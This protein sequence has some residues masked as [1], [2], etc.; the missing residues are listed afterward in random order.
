MGMRLSQKLL[1]WI[2][3]F[4]A[5]G[6]G[7]MTLYVILHSRTLITDMGMSDAKRTAGMAFE[8]LYASMSAGGGRE[9][10]RAVIERLSSIED[11]GEIRVIHGRPLD[12]QFGLMENRFP[13]DDLDMA[14]LAGRE[15]RHIE[16]GT[17]GE[18]TVRFVQPVFAG[19][20]CRR[21]HAVNEGEALG[22]ISISTSLSRYDGTLSRSVRRISIMGAGI[23]AGTAVM[24]VFFIVRVII[25]PVR[26][27]EKAARAIGEG[28]L[29]HRIEPSGSLEMSVLAD[30]FNRMTS[31]LRVISRELEKKVE[32]RTRELEKEM[33]VRK[34]SEEAVRHMAYH[35]PLTG[36]PNR[37]VLMDRVNQ[38]LA[39]GRWHGRIA[40][41]VYLDLDRFKVINDTLGHQ[42]GDTLLKAVADRLARCVRTGDTVVRQG[43]DEFIMLLQD[44]HRIDDITMVIKKVFSVFDSSFT[45][46]GRELAVTASIGISVYPDDGEDAE[47]LFK[48]AD[49]AMYK[50]KEEGRNK[51]KFFTPAMNSLF[52]KR[53]DIERRLLRAIEKEEFLLYYQPEVDISTG[54]V[55]GVEALLRWLDPEL[56]LLPP[57]DFIPVAEDTG[58]IIQIGEWALRAAC[59]QSKAWQDRGL[60]PVV[61][62]VNLSMRQFKQNDFLGSLV[63]ILEETGLDPAW[64]ELELTESIIMDDPESV[65]GTLKNLKAMG[66]RLTIDD[67]GTGYSSLEYLKRMPI[68]KLKIAQS[69]IKSITVDPDDV[70]I[71]STVI[72]IGHSMKMEVIAEGV[73]TVE[74]LLLLRTLRCDKVQ[75]FLVSRPAPAG[76]VERLLEKR[77]V[78]GPLWSGA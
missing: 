64:L 69:F 14:A 47:T 57:G 7:V 3:C 50:A 32:E 48:N 63:R 15:V 59:I 13:V 41:I 21:C 10:N 43:G 51:Y 77:G 61:V 23:L 27:F 34:R 16:R 8:A 45:V 40:A 2:I 19:E 9:E 70:A 36:L 76:E 75:G 55:A 11:M 28:G 30:E 37:L 66:V 62:A 29:A 42:A 52:L 18:G 46:A 68:N 56:G 74:Q 53:L 20:S 33:E 44:I 17:D 78:D 22:A 65:I 26:D 6:M 4:M 54:E 73:E 72:S 60:K 24:S 49:I 71:A 1:L 39:R 35:D 12:I 38:V 58:L 67:F 31:A 5:A 25:R